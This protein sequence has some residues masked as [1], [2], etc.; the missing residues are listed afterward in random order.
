MNT[1]DAARSL[2]IPERVVRFLGTAKPA[3]FCDD[4]IAVALALRRG[5]VS[6]VTST[7][8]LCG[9]YRRTAEPCASCGHNN[10]F[11]TRA[12]SEG[13]IAHAASQGQG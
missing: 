1:T 6:T 3:A 9:E 4:C 2:T 10:K 11:V 12:Q 5:Q 8:G 7:L 13:G